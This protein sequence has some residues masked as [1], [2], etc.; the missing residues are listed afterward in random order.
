[1][2]LAVSTPTELAVKVRVRNL[3]FYYGGHHAL[4]SVNLPIYAK[5][6]TSFIGPSG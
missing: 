1:M 6:V 2:N 3:D 4:K 5:K